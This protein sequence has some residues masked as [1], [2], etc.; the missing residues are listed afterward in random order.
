MAIEDKI[1]SSSAATPRATGLRWEL[2]TLWESR[3]N[4]ALK[5]GDVEEALTAYR[6]CVEEKA[7]VV[8]NLDAKTPKADAKRVALAGNYVGIALLQR[9][10]GRFAEVRAACEAAL[11]TLEGR[12]T[13]SEE[14]SDEPGV[15]SRLDGE[16]IGA[17]ARFLLAEL[18]TSGNV[19][20][21]PGGKIEKE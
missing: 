17:D 13:T 6:K 11:R 18:E 1:A 5:R 8:A 9:A 15:A 7:V 4:A 10:K 12:T 3:G 19:A 21:R 20:K 2:A 16:K 14:A